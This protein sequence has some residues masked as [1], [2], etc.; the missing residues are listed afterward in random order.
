MKKKKDPNQEI[1]V[2]CMFIGLGIGIALNQ[3][4]PGV[5]IGLGVGFLAKW[6]VK[7]K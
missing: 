7:K 1:F 2:A 3:T 5:L 4:A 6:I